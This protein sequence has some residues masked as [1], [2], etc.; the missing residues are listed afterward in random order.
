MPSFAIHLNYM[1]E[2]FRPAQFCSKK[3]ALIQ[4]GKEIIKCLTSAES[5][6]ALSVREVYQ[7]SSRAASSEDSSYEAKGKIFLLR[8]D[9]LMGPQK[10]QEHLQVID[11][12]GQS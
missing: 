11:P 9:D 8:G 12:G 2:G 5:W 10:T 3:R 6:L 1:E 7:K 4:L